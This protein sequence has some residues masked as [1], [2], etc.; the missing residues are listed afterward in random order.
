MFFWE[1]TKKGRWHLHWIVDRYIDVTWFRDWM[2]AR[3]WGQQMRV[4]ALLD[5]DCVRWTSEGWKLDDGVT[6]RL[7]RYLTKYLTKSFAVGSD[8]GCK[9][10]GGP[11]RCRVGTVAFKWMPAVDSRSFLYYWGKQLFM[12]LNGTLPTWRDTRA[13]IRLG[14]EACDWGNVDPWFLDTS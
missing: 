13:V 3:G 12:E 14:Y 11:A 8:K 2:T 6:K 1:K 7:I 5:K 4:E 9:I 10:W